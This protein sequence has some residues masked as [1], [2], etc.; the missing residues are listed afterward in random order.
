MKSARKSAPAKQPDG[1][2]SAPQSADP[3]IRKATALARKGAFFEA[4][5]IARKLTT[6]RPDDDEVRELRR[7]IL[8]MQLWDL[9]RRG[10]ASWSGGKPTGSNPPIPI[11]PGPP[12][13][14]YVIEDRG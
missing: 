2:D 1:E 9:V 5:A 11:T 8:D 6:E 14:G 13:S 7:E 4:V 10:V 12:V 3:R